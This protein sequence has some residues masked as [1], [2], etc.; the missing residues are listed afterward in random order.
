MQ[1][2]EFSAD[3]LSGRDGQRLAE[4]SAVRAALT[5][6]SLWEGQDI[7]HIMMSVKSILGLILLVCLAESIKVSG[8]QKGQLRQEE[9]K[10]E[11]GKEKVPD[12][13]T[14]KKA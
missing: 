4:V 12:E 5:R 2:L 9:E 10:E 6:V 3:Y 11:E 14:L 13:A 1:K 8:Q 7:R